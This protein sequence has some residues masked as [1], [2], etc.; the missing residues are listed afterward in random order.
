MTITT[1]FI[2]F[3]KHGDTYK[4][5]HPLGGVVTLSLCPIYEEWAS[6]WDGKPLG[7]PGIGPIE[8]VHTAS[9]SVHARLV[10]LAYGTMTGCPESA[11]AREILEQ[12]TK[13]N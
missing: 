1:P 6:T 9:L 11:R 7:T 8:A 4:G 3:L 10:E 5:E 12:H 13:G 2:K